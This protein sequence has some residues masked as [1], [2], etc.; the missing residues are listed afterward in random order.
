MRRDVA[1]DEFAILTYG[2]NTEERKEANG[3]LEEKE[4]EIINRAELRMGFEELREKL[5]AWE[6][7]KYRQAS[8]ESNRPGVEAILPTIIEDGEA[9]IVS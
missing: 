1:I 9:E 3:N 6:E 4:K 7:G 2:E 8:G 5:N